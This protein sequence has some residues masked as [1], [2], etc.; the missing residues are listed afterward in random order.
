[1]RQWK[2]EEIT[3]LSAEGEQARERLLA[4][5]A[6]SARVAERLR[7]AGGTSADVTAGTAAG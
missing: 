7:S 5:L 1:L 3:G 6:R 4:R 2:V